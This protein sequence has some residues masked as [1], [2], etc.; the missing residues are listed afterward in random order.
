MFIWL[1][2]FVLV[3]ITH[4]STLSKYFRYTL[5]MSEDEYV[6]CTVKLSAGKTTLKQH[7]VVSMSS[8]HNRTGSTLTTTYSSMQW[9]TDYERQ[10]AR[11]FHWTWYNISQEVCPT[12]LTVS[13]F[14]GLRVSHA[15]NTHYLSLLQT[16][17]RWQRNET[18]IP[19]TISVVAV[20][21]LMTVFTGSWDSF[22]PN[23]ST[24][25]RSTKLKMACTH[26]F[27]KSE[28]CEGG[29]FYVHVNTAFFAAIII[30]VCTR[31]ETNGKSVTI[32]DWSSHT[33]EP[34][35]RAC[36]YQF[37]CD[38]I[39]YKKYLHCLRNGATSNPTHTHH[40]VYSN[41]CVEWLM[42]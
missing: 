28:H 21:Q 2:L 14:S 12:T 31:G 27:L 42:H 34:D 19:W 41:A 3:W 13:I 20:H 38:C 33:Y 40:T 11:S 1:F 25:K 23:S 18:L 22:S 8:E 36:F 6:S 7:S 9:C 5:Y 35:H 39:L 32:C 24:V 29:S 37:S 16:L 26:N 15:D 4:S 10:S 30:R 17:D